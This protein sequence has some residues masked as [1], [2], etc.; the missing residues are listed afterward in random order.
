MQVNRRRQE[1]EV[2][3]ALLEELVNAGVDG[4]FQLPQLPQPATSVRHW[5][6]DTDEP[7]AEGIALV[8][9]RLEV[10]VPVARDAGQADADVLASLGIC[11]RRFHNCTLLW[12][13][14]EHSRI[15]RRAGVGPPVR[16]LLP[17]L[18]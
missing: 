4:Y 15:H 5:I 2:N 3:A 1:H 14:P 17:R 16:L 18:D 6:D 9:Q 11:C 10:R 8:Q 12:A 7:R 13:R